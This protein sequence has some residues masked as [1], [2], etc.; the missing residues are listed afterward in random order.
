[1]SLVA[2]ARAAP[3][4]APKPELGRAAEI[5]RIDKDLAIYSGEPELLLGVARAMELLRAGLPEQAIAQYDLIFSRWPG[6]SWTDGVTRDILAPPVTVQGARSVAPD[7]GQ[8]LRGKTYALLIGISHYGNNIPPLQFADE[9]AESFAKFLESPRGGSLRRCTPKRLTECEI[10]LLKNEEATLAHVASA[11]AEFV[12]EHA[13]P[14]NRLIVLIAAHGVYPDMQTS[15]GYPILRQPVILTADSDYADAKVTGYLMSDL[16][17]DAAR[18]ALVYGSAIVFADVCR[19][20]NI[21]SIAGSAN[22]Q[23]AVAKAWNSA[24]IGFLM[25]SQGHEDAY[26]SSQFGGGHGAFSYSVLDYLTRGSLPATLRFIDIES[27]L[28]K[29]VQELTRNSQ[30]PFGNANHKEMPV[31]YDTWRDTI[32]LGRAIPIDPKDT[33]RPK[34]SAV[35]ALRNPGPPQPV[36]PDDPI[37]AGRLRSDEPDGAWQELERL[38]TDPRSPPDLVD[39]YRERLRTALEDRGQM[40][41]LKYLKGDQIE[42]LVKDFRQCAADFEAALDLSPRSTY[43]RSR[44]LFCHA[45]ALMFG[46]KESDYTE[47]I[48]LLQQSTRLDGERSYAYNALGIAYFEQAVSDARLLPLAEAA[49]RDAIRYAPYWAYPRHNLALLSAERGDFTSAVELYRE[50]IKLAPAYPY[51]FYNLGLLFQRMN[52]FKDAADLY[53]KAANAAVNSMDYFV[54]LH[55]GRRRPEEAEALNALG[56]IIEKR[57]TEKAKEK[58]R[59]AINADPEILSARHN[60]AVLI[61]LKEPSSNEPEELWKEL[62]ARKPD[63]GPALAGYS[64]YLFHRGR[65][66]DAKAEYEILLQYSPDSAAAHRGLGAVLAALRRPEEALQ[67][68]QLAGS[69]L[70]DDAKTLEG[71]GDTFRAEGRKNDARDAYG[72]AAIALDEAGKGKAGRRLLAKGPGL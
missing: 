29:R 68:Y 34:A 58:Y 59:E 43:N 48:S 31:V 6:A 16:R 32:K 49:F 20:G 69:V 3:R 46:G 35:L 26:E 14:E 12:M 44:A 27:F 52:R 8:P 37:S 9:D 42:P 47:A 13:S 53:Q 62:L 5:E 64:G 4:R 25:A 7:A 41:I 72:L 60:R 71:L 33:R 11:F 50:A 10:W 15:P 57:S 61:A 66:E 22:L 65:L 67:Q 38:R 51:L 54:L 23:P 17:D 1:M 28:V 70:P 18:A 45:R 56:T 63:N 30:I 40:I 36:S 19:A 2:K 24:Q 55:G 39:A 21:G